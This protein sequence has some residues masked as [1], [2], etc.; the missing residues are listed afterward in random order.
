[1]KKK[2]FGWKDVEIHLAEFEKKQFLDLLHDLY[3]LSFDNK[4]FFHT[5]FAIGDDPLSTYKKT[6][7]NALNP[8]LEDGESLD[9]EKA[10]E[11]IN[12][13][14]RAVDNPKGEAELRIFYVECGNNFTLSYGYDDG[15]LFDSLLEMYEYAVETVLEFPE[16]EQNAFKSR[17]EEVMKSA[18]GIGWGYYDGLCDLFHSSFPNDDSSPSK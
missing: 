6:I 13:Y 18:S 5:R 9:I 17:L 2:E 10:Y 3:R 14:V 4:N 1:M 8:Y 7:Q 12:Q 11:A 15:D 16:K